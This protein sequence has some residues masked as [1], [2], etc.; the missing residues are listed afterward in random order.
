MNQVGGGGIE[1]Q[2]PWGVKLWLPTWMKIA[3]ITVKRMENVNLIPEVLPKGQT[4]GKGQYQ[5]EDGRKFN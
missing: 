1:L 4:V 3:P 2:I 5:L